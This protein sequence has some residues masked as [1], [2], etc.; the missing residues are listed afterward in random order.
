ML[1]CSVFKTRCLILLLSYANVDTVGQFHKRFYG[2]TYTSIGA[3]LLVAYI[4]LIFLVKLIPGA[5]VKR[6]YCP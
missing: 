2:I 6:L 1:P 3:L 5:N 4:N